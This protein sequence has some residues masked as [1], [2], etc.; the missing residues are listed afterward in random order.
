MSGTRTDQPV[1]DMLY[2]CACA[3]HGAAPD[4]G[5]LSGM[6]LAALL[7]LARAHSMAAM[8]CMALEAAD[9]FRG[10]DPALVKQWQDEKNKAIRKNILL[11]AEAD[12]ILRYM[13]EQGIWHMPLK[14]SVLKDFY[15]KCGMR[16][17][18]DHD[19]LFDSA[20]QERMRDYMVSRGYEVESYGKG[21]HDAYQKSPV[22][23]FELHRTLF[24]L[25]QDPAWVDYYSDVKTRLLPD[26]AGGCGFR[27]SDEDFYVYVT[28]H[29]YKHYTGGGT[30]LRCL[31]DCYVY[32][33]EKG[34]GLDWTYVRAELGKLGAAGFEEQ[35]RAMSAALFSAPSPG[36]ADGL[37]EEQQ[38]MLDYLAGSGTYG[39]AKNRVENR[40]RA[41]QR[42]GGP[43]DRRTRWRYYWRRLVPNMDWFR[44]NVPF[45]SRHRWAIPFF[46]VYRALRGLLLKRGKIR[47]EMQVAQ[48]K[49]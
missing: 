9:A 15:P 28:V 6:D 47:Y 5:A 17:M 19:I 14:G 26:G 43:V 35:C 36:A 20:G 48:G 18:S 27:F 11:D 22:Y 41:M 31:T 7:R 25:N 2:L 38:E 13:D 40:L 32:C 29:A 16:Q 39:T 42:D 8:V 30:G 46:L 1:R 49:K 24:N 45:C 44:A 37:T 33:R 3:L 12:Q 10:A 34:A 23:N 21:S 4:S